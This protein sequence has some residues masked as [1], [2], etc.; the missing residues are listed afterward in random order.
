M[1]TTPG[2]GSNPSFVQ[3]NRRLAAV[4]FLDMVGYSA[5]MAKDE[6]RALACVG[7]LE[8]LLRIEIPRAGGRLVKFLGDGSMAEFPTALSAVHCSINVLAVIEAN[9]A[10]TPVPNRYA[11]RIGLHLGE[12]VDVENDIFSDTVNVAAR[13]QP[14]AEPGGIAMTSLIY[15]QIKNQMDLKGTYLAPVKLKNIPE[16]I[17]I[18][19]VHPPKGDTPSDSSAQHRKLAIRISVGVV[20][21]LLAGWLVSLLLRK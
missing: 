3:Q 1:D 19:L 15:S 6:A 7:E 8:K 4:M 2:F 14:L 13:V 16:K 12:L 11:V 10:W 18:F 20:L 9:N 17:R 5:L 21:F